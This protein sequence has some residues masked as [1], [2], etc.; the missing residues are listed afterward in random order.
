M[1]ILKPGRI[2]MRK[3]VCPRC[4]CVFVAP[5]SLAFQEGNDWGVICP[6]EGCYYDFAGPGAPYEEPTQDDE[7]RIYGILLTAKP[8]AT[9]EELAKHL[10]AHGVKLV[11]LN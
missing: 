8:Q 10:I 3:F 2:E 6:Q 7:E 1:K 9:T 5:R 4:G 11:R